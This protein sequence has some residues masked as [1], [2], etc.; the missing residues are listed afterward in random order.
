MKRLSDSTES[1]RA[2]KRK[3]PTD[4]T[5]TD[6]IPYE[7]TSEP[8]QYHCDFCSKDISNSV[9]IRCSVC[10]EGA[11]DLCL[12]CFITGVELK[13]HQY[14]HNYRVID[15]MHFPFFEPGWSADEEY[16]LLEGLEESGVGNWTDI[17][18]NLSTK[19]PQQIKDHWTQF[20]LLSPQWPLIDYSN[21]VATRERVKE[22]NSGRYHDP[23]NK[24]KPKKEVKNNLKKKPSKVGAVTKQENPPAREEL[25]GYM[26]LRGEFET[27]WDNDYE[28]KVK[29]IA[30]EDGDTDEEVELKLKMLEVYNYRL[31]I[32]RK[33]CTFVVEKNLHDKK[34]LER[35]TK[36]RTRDH[37]E[38]YNLHRR[39]LQVMSPEEYEQFTR[40]LAE[41]KTLEARIGQLQEHR[42]KG[43]T[44]LAEASRFDD[45]QSSRES[46]KSKPSRYWNK[47]NVA[48]R[49][50]QPMDLEGQPGYSLLSEQE[51]EMC[52]HSHILPHQYFLAK[53]A[54][55][56]EYVKT[57]DVSKS[58]TS[59]LDT[60]KANRIMDFMQE[61]GWINNAAHSAAQIPDNNAA[62]N[63]SLGQSGSNKDGKETAL[64]QHQLSQQHQLAQHV[65]L[66]A[67]SQHA[68]PLESGGHGANGLRCPQF[69]FAPT[70]SNASANNNF[71]LTNNKSNSSKSTNNN[72]NNNN[73]NT[74]SAQAIG[75]SSHG[76]SLFPHFPTES[77]PSSKQQS[78]SDA[79]T[80]SNN[81]NTNHAGKPS[82]APF[83][84]NAPMPNVPLRTPWF[85]SRLP[86]SPI[87]RQT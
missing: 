69:Q 49:M 56:R 21:I 54:F 9:R 62:H 59:L 86:F 83:A 3:K 70:N 31:D 5:K 77:V 23:Y 57:G 65:L 44:S 71:N 53:E 15:N 84:F 82:A 48:R 40:G 36:S 30:F 41:Q 55:M 39:F 46:E 45:E 24:R 6:E 51:K 87:Q 7:S 68:L 81:N 28:N 74:S 4:V 2:N 76:L 26:P 17:A 18:E 37:Q 61:A 11:S 72:T 43:I 58:T 73:S 14:C 25:N 42:K 79:L 75:P 67:Q 50:N 10:P 38:L 27:E 29:D 80:N 85:G 60:D 66:A 52:R 64:H 33:R 35:Q 34:A 32:R 63:S 19:T 78:F 8:V 1:P 22:L 20:Y 12:E 13:G 47:K 16:L